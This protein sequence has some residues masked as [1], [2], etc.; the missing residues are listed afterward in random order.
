M[1]YLLNWNTVV[2]FFKVLKIG[3]GV[4]SVASRRVYRFDKDVKLLIVTPREKFLARILVRHS[5]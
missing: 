2:S 5:S 1:I 3:G 4:V